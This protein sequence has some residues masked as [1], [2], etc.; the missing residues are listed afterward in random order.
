MQI[1]DGFRKTS[2]FKNQVDSKLA[3][4]LNFCFVLSLKVSCCDCLFEFI[5]QYVKWFIFKNNF[6]IENVVESKL[7]NKTQSNRNGH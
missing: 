5:V 3:S 6:F 7:F 2:N 4:C 1:S